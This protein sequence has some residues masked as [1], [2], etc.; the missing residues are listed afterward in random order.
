[1]H[2]Q[3]ISDLRERL[4]DRI[5]AR[6]KEWWE[7]YV[8]DGAPFLGVKMSLIRSAVE[9]WY[10]EMI[11]DELEPEEQIELA[12]DL[13]REEYSEEKLAGILYLQVILIPAGVVSC[14]DKILDF[15]AVFG[16]GGIY[17][18]NICDWFAVKVLGPLIRQQGMACAQAVSTWTEDPDIWQARSSLVSFV[19][20]AGESEYYPLI[21]RGCAAMLSR[22]ERFAQTAVGWVLREV[23]R[24][25]PEFVERFVQEKSKLFSAESLCEATRYL[26]D[27]EDRH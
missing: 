16:I 19:K 24:Y 4:E 12:L 7:N 1:M 17:D 5:D 10:D 2:L 15:A 27:V 6:A 8:A 26:G 20:V 22:P 18:W 25:S 23:S 3:L 13:I 11:A 14:P 21:E 9:Q